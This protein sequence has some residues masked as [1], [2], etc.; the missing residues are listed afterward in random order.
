MTD[1]S[2]I[3]VSASNAAAA[4]NLETE[5]LIAPSL[6]RE[7]NYRIWQAVRMCPA[8]VLRVLPDGLR[9]ILDHWINAEIQHHGEKWVAEVGLPML[10][11]PTFGMTPEGLRMVAILKR[12]E[13]ANRGANA[14][15]TSGE[16]GGG[17]QGPGARRGCALACFSRRGRRRVDRSHGRAEKFR[18]DARH[19][20]QGRAA[21]RVLHARDQDEPVQRRVR[22]D[23]ADH[24]TVP[25]DVPHFLLVYQYLSGLG[26][27]TGEPA[28]PGADRAWAALKRGARADSETGEATDVGDDLPPLTNR[29]AALLVEDGE[30]DSP[31]TDEDDE[32]KEREERTTD[33]ELKRRIRGELSRRGRRR[34]K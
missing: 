13:G 33:D 7:D 5:L 34:R 10:E 27:N 20:D 6:P 21:G 30:Q 15:R 25:Q 19:P 1:P 11:V 16:E 4:D 2:T 24:I 29:F 14:G 28:P 31:G 22:L 18:S 17:G 26:V 23:R 3:V 32:E 12:I 9:R 8:A